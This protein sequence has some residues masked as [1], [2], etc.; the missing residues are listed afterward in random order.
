MYS[1]IPNMF[2]IVSCSKRKNQ[3]HVRCLHLFFKNLNCP[4]RTE[5]TVFP[6][7]PP[8]VL[9]SAMSGGTRPG[10]GVTGRMSLKK[11]S[12]ISKLDNAAAAKRAK[13]NEATEQEV[14]FALMKAEFAA[15][16]ANKEAEV[17]ALKAQHA[18]QVAALTAQNA[19]H[20]NQV[21]RQTGMFRAWGSLPPLSDPQLPSQL[22]YTLFLI[23]F[24]AAAEL[25]AL[26][27]EQQATTV[28]FKWAHRPLSSIFSVSSRDTRNLMGHELETM[29]NFVDSNTGIFRD[30]ASVN[31]ELIHENNEL[32]Y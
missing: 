3:T 19:I 23:R 1:S 12:A 18:V 5:V 9:F 2:Y 21:A 27:I 16:M 14:Q 11:R 26:R 8:P 30:S 7:Q 6:Q 29:I 22:S 32:L 28:A 20:E 4:R 24:F 13:R 17:I 25:T 15:T 31:I 10:A